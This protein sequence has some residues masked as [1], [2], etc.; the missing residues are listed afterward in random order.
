M[1]KKK[2]A[3]VIILSSVIMWII[4]CSKEQSVTQSNQSS[5]NNPYGWV[6]KLHNEG[7]NFAKSRLSKIN[8]TITTDAVIAV[9]EEFMVSKEDELQEYGIKPYDIDYE[10]IISYSK[11]VFA[12]FVGY[13]DSCK[14]NGLI[15]ET[16]FEYLSVILQYADIQDTTSISSLAK[17]IM[18]SN[19]TDDERSALLSVIAVGISSAEYWGTES[20]QLAKTMVPP[21]LLADVIGAIG[22][23]I[24]GVPG[25]WAG[26]GWGALGGA[27]AGSLA[28]WLL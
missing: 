25:G 12:N 21:I 14:S 20:N 18:E 27:V 28:M 26:V 11:G 2:Y 10:S 8:G 24:A 19:L 9:T 15:S 13:L 16:Y 7:L 4:G 5:F 1:T 3:T 22:G 6:G 17:E 23:A